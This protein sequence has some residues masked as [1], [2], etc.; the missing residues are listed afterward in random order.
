MATLLVVPQTL[1]AHPFREREFLVALACDNRLRE[2][3][4][5]DDRQRCVRDVVC[6]SEA[7]SVDPVVV[8]DCFETRKV[9]PALNRFDC[10]PSGPRAFKITYTVYSYGLTTTAENS[11]RRRDD[12]DCGDETRPTLNYMFLRRN[13]R[14]LSI[15]AGEHSVL[16]TPKRLC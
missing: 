12:D 1:E 8:I 9:E 11:T 13:E 5:Q 4:S 7:R 15:N 14:I 2:S 10:S 3:E 6:T 16:R